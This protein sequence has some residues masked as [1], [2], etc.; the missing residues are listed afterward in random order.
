[1]TDDGL[2]YDHE[3]LHAETLDE[4]NTEGA[5]PDVDFDEAVREAGK[6][7]AEEPAAT[8]ATGNF[9]EQDSAIHPHD[10]PASTFGVFGGV[11]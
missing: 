9:A 10:G 11:D 5:D 2:H 7:G 8:G 3:P 6:V 1:M 4:L